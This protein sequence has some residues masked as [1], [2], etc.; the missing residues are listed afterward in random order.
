MHQRIP[1]YA[2][3]QWLNHPLLRKLLSPSFRY[4]GTGRRGHDKVT[5]VL[6][7]M[8]KKLHGCSYRD[9]ESMSGIDYTTFIKFNTRL[10][11]VLWFPKLFERLVGKVLASRGILNLILD[12]SFVETY[13][14]H[15]EEGS[16]YSG[17]KEKNGYKTH[18]IIDFKTRLPLFQMVS[19]GNVA[20]I[21][22][23]E[24]LVERA[25]PTLHVRS[26]GADK[27]YDSEYFVHRIRTK[28]KNVRVAIPVRKKPGDD[29]RNR[30]GRAKERSCDP[31]LYRK[32][33]EIER[34]YSRKKRVFH[35]GEEHTRTL[36]NFR[37]NAFLASSMQILEYLTHDAA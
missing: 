11:K 31:R 30:A 35:L 25:P 26:F 37:A 16:G 33:T 1:A 12:S 29:G 22:A 13:S 23:G 21:T 28:W 24:Q 34:H 2:R 32:R 4:C 7:L 9:L 6:W 20:D 5:M 15:D 27:G 19:A 10:K 3:F 18:E 36:E 14:K 17:Y 8:Y